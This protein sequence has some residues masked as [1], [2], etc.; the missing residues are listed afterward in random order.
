LSFQT[1]GFSINGN[2]VELLGGMSSIGDNTWGVAST[3]RWPQIFTNVSGT[4]TL[5]API[6]NNNNPLTILANE[7]VL[8]DGTIAGGAGITKTGPGSLTLAAANTYT[9]PTLV[10]GG[11]L[12]VSNTAALGTTASI[13]IAD[14]AVLDTRAAPLVVQAGQNL[15]GGGQVVGQTLVRG[16]VYP[17]D[18]IG[19]LS[20][21]GELA[22]EG[23]TILEIAKTNSTIQADKVRVSGAIRYGGLLLVKSLGAPMS[24]GDVIRP[25]EATSYTGQFSGV[26]L[27]ALTPPLIWD[28]SRLDLDGT[29][30][31][32]LP[33]GPELVPVGIVDGKLALQFEG[34]P[35]ATYE[36]QWADSPSSTNWIIDGTLAGSNGMQLLN[37]P[38]DFGTNRFFRFRVY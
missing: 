24:L 36:I 6:N 23:S 22:L 7:R 28:R 21:V 18:S 15:A 20:F 26:A 10:S 12:V 2:P 33:N 35:G 16:S 38:I 17:G 9:G 25:F 5:A 1:G 14:G 32:V 4:L 19:T 29:F 30:K 8:A 31:V 34:F 11:S 37:L 13:N 3:L 27:P